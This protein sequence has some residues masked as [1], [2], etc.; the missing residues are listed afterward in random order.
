MSIS[1][2][3]MAKKGIYCI[4]PELQ[5]K[6][7]SNIEKQAEEE[8]QKEVKWQKREEECKFKLQKVKEKAIQGEKLLKGDLK[9]LVSPYK[10][11][12]DSPVKES[13][14]DLKQQYENK[15]R[16]HIMFEHQ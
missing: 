3:T 12:K 1:S 6:V 11:E 16:V 15:T 13:A 9:L 2:G 14:H 7:K 8:R 4:G 5:D 10:Q